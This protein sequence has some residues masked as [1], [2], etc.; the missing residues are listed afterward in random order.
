MDAQLL[1]AAAPAGGSGWSPSPEISGLTAD[2]REV[3][4]GY[5][6]AALP[7]SKLDGRRFIVD[8]MSRGAAAV[9]TDDPSGLD[10]LRGGDE[11]VAIVTDPNPR[12][13][14]ALMAARFHAPQPRTIA[15]ITG[16][17]GKTS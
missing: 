2:S 3:R 5:L 10:A 1:S 9:L 15:A 16:T 17:S 4:P 13:R 14:L 6:F 11:P 12:R 7:G 8:A